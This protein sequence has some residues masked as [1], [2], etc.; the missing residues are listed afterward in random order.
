MGPTLI[1]SVFFSPCNLGP[2]LFFLNVAQF[3]S[4]YQ[5]YTWKLSPFYVRTATAWLFLVM[6]DYQ[7]SYESL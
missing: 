1:F 4:T 2:W 7:M 5:I 6:N 3:C